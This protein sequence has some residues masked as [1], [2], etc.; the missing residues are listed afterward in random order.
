MCTFLNFFFFF[1]QSSM[2]CLTYML[3]IFFS[4]TQGLKKLGQSIESSYS[5]IQKLVISHLQRY[6][7]D[8]EFLVLC[9]YVLGVG[10]LHQLSFFFSLFQLKLLHWHLKGILECPRYKESIMV[11]FEI[12]FKHLFT[13]VGSL[14][15]IFF[16]L[17]QTASMS[18]EKTY[19]LFF[20]F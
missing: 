2:Q 8:V 18:F 14:S 19:T 13:G 9:L 20:F 1:F 16:P 4:L 7:G 5:S 6:E 3:N 17:S 15:G 11:H 12:I 10:V